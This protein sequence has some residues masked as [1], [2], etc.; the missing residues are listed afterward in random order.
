[1][2]VAHNTIRHIQSNHRELQYEDS[3]IE[4]NMKVTVNLS[5]TV[6]QRRT[7]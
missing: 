1:M 4:S 3:G 5:M 7:R 6:T 2:M